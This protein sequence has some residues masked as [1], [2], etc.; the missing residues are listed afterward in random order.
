MLQL[1]ATEAVRE[2]FN[3]DTWMIALS[4]TIEENVSLIEYMGTVERIYFII[5]D[6]RFENEVKLEDAINL[7]KHK[8]KTSLVR[9]MKTVD[10]D[11][12]DGRDRKHS[13]EQMQYPVDWQINNNTTIDDLDIR[14]RVYVKRSLGIKG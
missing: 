9:V 11:S 3:I 5:P 12:N 1:F 13:S 8:I 10:S 2:H 7:P 14:C 6:W 4:N